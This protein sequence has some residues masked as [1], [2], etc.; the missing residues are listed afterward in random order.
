MTA[1]LRD[2][3]QGSE[4]KFN[5][6]EEQARLTWGENKHMDLGSRGN[7]HR[8]SSYWLC[9]H[10]CVSNVF[11]LPVSCVMFQ[12]S[13]KKSTP[14]FCTPSQ[15]KACFAQ[16]RILVFSRKVPPNCGPRGNGVDTGQT[17]C[18]PNIYIYI[19]ICM[20]IYIYIYHIIYHYVC[21]YVCMYIY[22]YIYIYTTRIY[23]FIYLFVYLFIYASCAPPAA[24]R[25]AGNPEPLL[26]GI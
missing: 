21:M 20:Y 9:R 3:F 23:S 15:D 13:V 6:D 16:D 26:R 10:G 25:G 22:I 14:N 7:S 1:S 8:A 2:S 4:Y 5:S 11:T 17:S 18:A 24:A 19:Y 12:K